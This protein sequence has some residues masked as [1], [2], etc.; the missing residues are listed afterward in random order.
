[1]IEMLGVLAIIGVL[2]VGG[3]AG[4]S[5]AMFEY[6]AGILKEQIS[7]LVSAINRHKEKLTIS[8]EGGSEYYLVEVLDAMNELPDG[9]YYNDDWLKDVFENWVSVYHTPS[10][11]Y[12][13]IKISFNPDNNG[14]VMCRNYVLI[15]QALHDSISR[16][17]VGVNDPNFSGEVN[18]SLH[19]DSRCTN[20]TNC[21]KDAT[22]TD[23]ENMCRQCDND[24]DGI[25][26]IYL[27][28]YKYE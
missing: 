27:N 26:N 21:L 19:G 10:L 6:K 17:T 2:S 28:A 22:L 3:I 15:S 1:M 4:Y 5:K 14:Y 11:K 9:M 13:G 25:C 8:G 7:T 18:H 16:I 12:V 24:E 23:I 20:G